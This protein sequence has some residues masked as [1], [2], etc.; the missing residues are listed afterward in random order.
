MGGKYVPQQVA[1]KSVVQLLEVLALLLYAREW[2][3][4]SVDR[5]QDKFNTNQ[6][7]IALPMDR[8]NSWESETVCYLSL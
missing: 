2:D 4:L 6:E 7:D 5:A 8:I 3:L 1:Q